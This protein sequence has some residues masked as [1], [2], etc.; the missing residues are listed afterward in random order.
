MAVSPRPTPPLQGKPLPQYLDFHDKGCTGAKKG[1]QGKRKECALLT[2]RI[3]S[4]CPQ[5]SG[6]LEQNSEVFLREED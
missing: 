2:V 6:T 1:K 5:L 3:Y 4:V